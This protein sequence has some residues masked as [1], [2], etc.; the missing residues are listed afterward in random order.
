MQKIGPNAALD[1]DTLDESIIRELASDARLSMT[2]LARRVG[3]SKTPVLARVRRLEEAGLITGYHA[4]LSWP[5]LGLGC[6]TFVQVR[7][8]DTR[9]KALKAFNAAVARLTE[10]EECHMIASG[11]DYLLK[12]RTQD[13]ASYREVMGEKLSELPH[14]ASTSSF[15]ALEVVKDG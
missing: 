12:V 5:K 6:V 7:L 4:T 11:F 3:L 2:E 1:L 15:V 10:V 8:T 14:V 9:E 13:V